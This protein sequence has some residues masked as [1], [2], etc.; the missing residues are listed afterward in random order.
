MHEYGDKFNVTSYPRKN[1]SGATVYSIGVSANNLS[2]FIYKVNDDGSLSKCKV[3]DG[4]LVVVKTADVG[5]KASELYDSEKIDEAV[6]E[7]EDKLNESFKDCFEIQV[8]KVQETD[9]YRI[10]LISKYTTIYNSIL[11]F[12]ILFPP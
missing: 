9:D 2:S 3:Q 6:E 5:Y 10:I 1:E 8:E 7:I 12:I 4:K 11:S